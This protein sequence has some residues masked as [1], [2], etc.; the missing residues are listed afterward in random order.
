MATLVVP[1]STAA[2]ER[3]RSALTLVGHQDQS[4]QR[5]VVETPEEAER[6]GFI[7]SPTILWDGRDPFATGN[8]S[9]RSSF[10]ILGEG[11]GVC[12]LEVGGGANPSG[13]GSRA[14]SLRTEAR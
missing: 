13:A 2:E 5:V 14:P 6:L 4:N 11:W 1:N 7:G 10:G 12:G 8:V 3:L 9:L